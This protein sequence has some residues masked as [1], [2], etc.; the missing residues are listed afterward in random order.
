MS[1]GGFGGAPRTVNGLP[2]FQVEHRGRHSPRSRNLS[3]KNA[4]TDPKIKFS[5]QAASDFW[6]KYELRKEQ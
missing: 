5:D 2:T 4:S 1:E 6:T 3:V